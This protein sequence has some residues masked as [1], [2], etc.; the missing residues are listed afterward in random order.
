MSLGSEPVTPDWSGGED[1]PLEAHAYVRSR[2]WEEDAL[3]DVPAFESAL[4]A[5]GL[6][7]EDV[8]GGVD[9]AQVGRNEIDD[10]V[11]DFWR[12]QDRRYIEASEELLRVV[13]AE[14]RSVMSQAVARL[15][16]WFAGYRQSVEDRELVAV[17]IPL[18]VLAAAASDGSTARYESS[19][20][21]ERGLGWTVDVAGTGMAGHAVVTSSV[22]S[23]FEAKAG[24]VVLVHLPLTVAVELVRTTKADGST[25]STHTQINPWPDTAVR[26]APGARLLDAGR[27]PGPGRLLES[28]DLTGYPATNLADYGFRYQQQRS[29]SLNLGVKGLGVALTASGTVTLT[30]AVDLPYQLSGGRKYELHAATAADGLVWA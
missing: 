23:G 10:V 17:E 30:D 24:Q 13:D 7:P 26:P 6:P 25:I 4:Q 14:R 12:S 11:T 22:T 20:E 1:L 27:G 9:Q 2:G 16:D 19:R 28:Y 21:R 18:F 15:R 8:A 5:I 3:D 29:V